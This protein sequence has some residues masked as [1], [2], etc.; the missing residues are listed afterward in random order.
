MGS[1]C[2]KCGEIWFPR[3]EGVCSKCNS[4]DIIDYECSHEGTVLHHWMNVFFMQNMG[5]GE[6]GLG[7]VPAVI[8]LDD[9]PCVLSE[10]IECPP[11]EVKDGMKVRMV[12]R[13]QKRETNGNW[14]YGYKFVASSTN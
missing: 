6:Y 9:G 3:R 11:Q 2:N 1:K 5:Y 4:Q 12:V 8:K 14:M 7:R 10:V 13:K